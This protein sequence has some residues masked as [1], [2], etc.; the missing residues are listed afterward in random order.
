MSNAIEVTDRFPASTADREAIA[1]ND[2]A[3]AKAFNDLRAGLPEGRVVIACWV[4]SQFSVKRSYPIHD[5][6]GLR[7]VMDGV[8]NGRCT[9]LQFF[10]ELKQRAHG[11]NIGS[12]DL[13]H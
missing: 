8:L 6:A 11:T 9:E 13:F 1:T 7:Y 5:A 2:S 12:R 3:A 10:H 4:K